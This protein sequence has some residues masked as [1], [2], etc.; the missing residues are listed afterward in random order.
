[1][2]QPRIPAVDPA[3]TSGKTRDLLDGVQKMLGAT[4]NLFR[5][6]AQSPAVLESLVGLFGAT[7]HASLRPS[8]RR[9]LA[10][11]VAETNGCEYCLSAHAYLGKS[12]GMSEAEI[13]RARDAASSDP[14]TAAILRFARTLVVERG[15][16]GD[17]AM[18]AVRAAGAT[19]AE[20]LEIVAVVVLNVFTNYLN[21]VAQTEIDFPK[22]S[23]RGPSQ[24]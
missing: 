10:M 20:V 5:T 18:R 16:V 22:I 12:A 24:P 1:M 15:Q 11:L 19:D 7:A 3:H 8:V 6:A 2:S 9:A 13:D 21:L 4:P 17:E 14:K 23:R